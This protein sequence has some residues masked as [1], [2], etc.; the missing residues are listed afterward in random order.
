MSK[1]APKDKPLEL[2]KS[3]LDGSVCECGDLESEHY[4]DSKLQPDDCAYCNSCKKFRP[5]AFKVERA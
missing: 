2:A 5:V 4:L 3:L 1:K